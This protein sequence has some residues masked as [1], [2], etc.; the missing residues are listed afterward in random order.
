MNEGKMKEDESE[1]SHKLW[2]SDTKSEIVEASFFELGVA[3]LLLRVE[4]S[5]LMWFGNIQLVGDPTLEGLHISTGLE[6][7]PDPH[8]PKKRSVW[9]TLLSLK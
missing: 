9:V 4:R 6:T 8:P 5:Q 1:N 7:P 2:V 3:A